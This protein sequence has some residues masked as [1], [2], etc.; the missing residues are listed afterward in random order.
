LTNTDKIL[1]PPSSR[2]QWLVAGALG[3]S[4]G[5]A[6]FNY[7]ESLIRDIGRYALGWFLVAVLLAILASRLLLAQAWPRL[8][9]YPRSHRVL[10]IAGSLIAGT[11]VLVVV[12]VPAVPACQQLVITAVGKKE[13][14]SKGSEVWVPPSQFVMDGGWEYVNQVPVSYRN[15]P[16]SLHWTACLWGPAQLHLCAHP[17]SGVARITW[18]DQSQ[19]ENLYSTTSIE[20]VFDLE[21]QAGGPWDRTRAAIGYGGAALGLGLLV[22][23]LGLWLVAQPWGN[24]KSAP[25]GRWYWLRFALPCAGIWSVCLLAFWPAIMSVDSLNQWGQMITGLLVDIHPPFTR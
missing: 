15:Q 8:R 22:L 2:P 14:A 19:T 1:K 18:G 6:A 5:W 25:V 9:G 13:L 7:L 12:P 11:V 24:Y 10:W 21:P 23:A 17:F 20:K 4:I 16:A 3:L